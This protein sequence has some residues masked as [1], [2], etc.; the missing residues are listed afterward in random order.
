[1]KYN[2]ILKSIDY[3]YWNHANVKYNLIGQMI[4]FIEI[5][6]MRCSILSL[7]SVRKKVCH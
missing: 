4:I 1:M 2:L 7:T 5:M 6:L 3:F